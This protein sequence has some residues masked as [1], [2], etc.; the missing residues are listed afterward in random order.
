[1]GR[2]NNSFIK[3]LKAEKKKKKKREKQEKKEER[4]SQATGGSLKEMIA[5][6]DENGNITTEPPEEM[7]QG[8][9]IA[10]KQIAKDEEEHNNSN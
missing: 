4:R 5:Y 2:S 8:E 3:K 6:L 7:S 9:K 10:T 1:M